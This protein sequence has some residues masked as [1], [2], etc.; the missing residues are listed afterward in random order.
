MT[1]TLRTKASII[2]RRSALSL[3]GILLLLSGLVHACE[4]T[5]TLG[6][7]CAEDA[8]CGGGLK[9]INRQC[10]TEANPPPS[11]RFSQ[12]C[13]PYN[14]TRGQNCFLNQNNYCCVFRSEEFVNRGCLVVRYDLYPPEGRCACRLDE[15]CP[16]NM[17]CCELHA[18]GGDKGVKSCALPDEGGA[19][20]VINP[21]CTA[22]KVEATDDLDKKLDCLGEKNNYCCSVHKSAGS[23]LTFSVADKKIN[24]CSCTDGNDCPTGMICCP[25]NPASIETSSYFCSLPN[26]NGV[27]ANAPDFC[28]MS[29][30]KNQDCKLFPYCC[31]P[32]G[33]GSCNT[34]RSFSTLLGKEVNRCSCESDADCPR[35]TYCCQSSLFGKFCTGDVKGSD[36]CEG[37]CNHTTGQD[38]DC[39]A[40][41]NFY[42]CG[43]IN[44]ACVNVGGQDKQAFR[45]A[46]KNGKGCPGSLKCCKS[47]LVE[48]CNDS[49][50]P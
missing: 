35:N 20:P 27:C 7:L 33:K 40:P 45:C 31:A 13:G 5:S 10:G 30:V 42:C 11:L 19:C 44:E 17:K 12:S 2:P 24:R 37:S 47:G 6:L 8:D 16:P 25:T 22:P 48:F 34:F 4:Q 1:L 14:S 18:S 29:N 28:S 23:C 21:S 41:G 43:K 50:P 32:S 15:D 9:C 38:L 26:E 46:C 36:T 39:S 3:L 49:C